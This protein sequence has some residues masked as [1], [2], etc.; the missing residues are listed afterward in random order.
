MQTGLI[1]FDAVAKINRINIDL[2]SIARTYS[3]D[4]DEIELNELCE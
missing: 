2:R 4:S 1:A 3:L